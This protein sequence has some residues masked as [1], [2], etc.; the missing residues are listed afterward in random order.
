M[1]EL[2]LLL[3]IIKCLRDA[4]FTSN[5]LAIKK[6]TCMKEEYFNEIS[7]IRER[8]IPRFEG[9]LHHNFRCYSKD[10]FSNLSDKECICYELVVPITDQNVIVLQ[11]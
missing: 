1:W 6:I 7:V 11:T 2:L 8:N 9:L 3:I 5:F 4:T 10:D